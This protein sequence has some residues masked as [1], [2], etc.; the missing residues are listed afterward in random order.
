M[1]D[2]EGERT[3]SIFGQFDYSLG[4]QHVQRFCNMFSEVPPACLGRM[5]AAVQPTTCGTLRKHVTKSSEQVAA[6]DRIS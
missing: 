5:A 1:G 4:R 6:P 3:T 2:G